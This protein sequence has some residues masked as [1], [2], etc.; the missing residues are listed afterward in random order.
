ML[1]T[2]KVNSRV[3][4]I[5]KYTSPDILLSSK[6]TPEITAKKLIWKK[7]SASTLGFELSI[8]LM[9]KVVVVSQAS[10]FIGK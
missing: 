9:S 8:H 4:L 7:D 6:A 5:N 3:L 1:E 2:A 10:R